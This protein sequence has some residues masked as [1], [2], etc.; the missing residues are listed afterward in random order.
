EWLLERVDNPQVDWLQEMIEPMLAESRNKSPNSRGYIFE[1]KW[2]GIRAMISLDEEG[3]RIRSRNQR[4]IT[5]HFPELLIPDKAFRASCG[6]FDVE[7]VCLDR[8]GKP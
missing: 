6:L 4:D 3:I 1:V 8:N 2:D 5:K 7:I